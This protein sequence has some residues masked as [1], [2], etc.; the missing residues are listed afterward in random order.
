MPK[1]TRIIGVKIRGLWGS[2]W[3]KAWEGKTPSLVK[4]A[5]IGLWLIISNGI[6]FA[7]KRDVTLEIVDITELL[8][9]K[10]DN[11]SIFNKKLEHFYNASG[12]EPMQ[13]ISHYFYFDNIVG[14]KAPEIIH[15]SIAELSRT[16]KVDSKDISE[17]TKKIIIDKV[18][19][20][21]D[22]LPDNLS[23]DSRLII[24]CLCD[25]L[26]LAELKSFVSK[27]FPGSSN[28]SILELKTI[29]NLCMMALGKMSNEALRPCDW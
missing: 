3:S 7:P 18:A 22:L 1:N 28:P 27:N 16:T 20:M 11:I 6:F 14:K 12:E 23:L 15:G 9:V 25:S 2:R 26:D 13:Y 5:L 8:T 17:D 29:G 10:T 21:K 24:D 19:T 4:T